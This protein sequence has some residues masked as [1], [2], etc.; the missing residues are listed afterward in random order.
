MRDLL[1]KPYFSY[2]NPIFNTLKLGLRKSDRLF[3]TRLT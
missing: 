1:K 3:G 2:A